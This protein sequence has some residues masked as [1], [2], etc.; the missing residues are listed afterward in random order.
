MPG[1]LT[2]DPGVGGGE[3]AANDNLVC[4]RPIELAA[5][6]I[7]LAKKIA[8]ETLGALVQGLEVGGELGVGVSAKIKG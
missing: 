2:G 1:G 4:P 8:D 7:L 6:L 3:L 5:G